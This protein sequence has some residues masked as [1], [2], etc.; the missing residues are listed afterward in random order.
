M[1]K[2]HYVSTK[3]SSNKI[4]KMAKIIDTDKNTKMKTWA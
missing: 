3:L 4:T 2:T 1:M